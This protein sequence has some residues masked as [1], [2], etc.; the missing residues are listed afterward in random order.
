MPLSSLAGS[1]AQQALVQL[2]MHLSQLWI[3]YRDLHV[4]LFDLNS[5]DGAIST[6]QELAAAENYLAAL[7]SECCQ[8]ADEAGPART[9]TWR[10]L[11]VHG[12]EELLLEILHAIHQQAARSLQA[13]QT[14][15]KVKRSLSCVC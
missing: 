8:A 7:M 1:D 10:L 3:R 12:E 14:F 13:L 4:F 6:E 9:P 11:R 15:P 5:Q 2:G